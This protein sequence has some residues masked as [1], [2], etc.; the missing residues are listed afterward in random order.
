M[1]RPSQPPARIVVAGAWKRRLMLVLAVLAAIG[2]GM[3]VGAGLT[4]LSTRTEAI[5]SVGQG[6]WRLLVDA[7]TPAINPYLRAYFA[8]TGQVPLAAAQGLTAVA[9]RDSAG[10][11]LKR[12]CAYRVT[13]P[14]PPALF[15][16]LEAADTH[17]VPFETPARRQSFTSEDILRDST[18]KFAIQI[19]PRVQSGNW[20]P[21]AGSGPFLL[22]LRLYE[23]PMSGAGLPIS[24]DMAFP[25]VEPLSCP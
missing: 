5:G 12:N 13:G 20:S 17:G 3:I 11:L 4:R 14:V 8:R 15:W 7:G 6:P 21:I 25:T 9:R 2:T 16:T 23:T 10:R 19:A 1:R 22:V 24:H 18:G